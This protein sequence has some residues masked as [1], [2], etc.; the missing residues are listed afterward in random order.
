MNPVDVLSRLRLVSRF[1]QPLRWRPTA[2]GLPFGD[3]P[4]APWTMPT[5][6]SVLT[7][8]AGIAALLVACFNLGI[9]PGLPAV[10]G[11]VE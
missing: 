9:Y 8:T 11:A 1:W 3:Q 4:G 2:W 5:G 7:V 10:C 6:L